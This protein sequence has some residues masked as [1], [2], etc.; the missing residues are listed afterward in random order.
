[1]KFLKLFGAVVA[2]YLL[3]S[4]ILY[5]IPKPDSFTEITSYEPIM[6][7]GVNPGC[8]LVKNNKGVII[9]IISETEVQNHLTNKSNINISSSLSQSMHYDAEMSDFVN[10]TGGG[11]LLNMFSSLGSIRKYKFE[12]ACKNQNIESASSIISNLDLRMLNNLSNKIKSGENTL[13]IVTSVLIGLEGTIELSDNTYGL[14]KSTIQEVADTTVKPIQIDQNHENKSKI[15]YT[16]QNNIIGYKEEYISLTDITQALQ[17]MEIF[18]CYNFGQA[19]IA[20]G[21]DLIDFKITKAEI[22]S[23]GPFDEL[24]LEINIPFI[25]DHNPQVAPCNNSLG[26]S[27]Y[28]LF[29][30]YLNHQELFGIP[31][32][33]KNNNLYKS[34]EFRSAA[35]TPAKSPNDLIKFNMPIKYELIKNGL[36]FA[37]AVPHP[38][39]LYNTACQA[40]SND[41]LLRRDCY[42]IVSKNN[43][44]F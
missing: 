26:Y 35:T 9:S 7:S 12:G 21:S 41:P 1:M 34:L 17:D 3:C 39:N 30:I 6:M 13:S 4:I 43:N 10:L 8:I 42:V 20:P 32:Y 38:G 25:K 27:Y 24:W 40:N 18:H 44:N 23:L 33:A 36:T 11:S 14:L 22:A 29:T 37:I 16:F 5:L 15:L 2:I 31:R 28:V 19:Q